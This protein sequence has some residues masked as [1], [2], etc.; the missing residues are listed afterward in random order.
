MTECPTR[1]ERRRA[2]PHRF[3]EPI[4][5]CGPAGLSGSWHCWN[6]ATALKLRTNSRIFFFLT[7]TVERCSPRNVGGGVGVGV[8]VGAGVG[9]LTVN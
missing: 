3:W 9:A 6:G 5:W 4:S 1:A 7:F 8:G 2:D